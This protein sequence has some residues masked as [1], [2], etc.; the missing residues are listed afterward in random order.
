MA[1]P[2]TPQVKGVVFD[3]DGVLADTEALHLAA[4][5]EVFSKRGWRLEPQEYFSRYL[6]YDDRGL[7][8][9]FARDHGLHFTPPDTDR[10]F[11][12]KAAAYR[13]RLSAGSVL[14]AGATACITRLHKRFPLAIATGSLRD[15]VVDILTASGAIAAFDA[16]VAAD[17]GVD[18]KPSPAPYLAAASR[19]GIPPASCVA[20]EDSPGGLGSAVEAGL[21]TIGI[22]TTRLRRELERATH[23]VDALDEL[24]V[25][26][27]ESL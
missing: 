4:F 26:L 1:T 27:I 19:L 25:E 14:Y 23:V 18:P 6:G 17:D 2:V 12:E 8:D 11:T 7:I 5:Q 9:A 24:T 15:E 20:I 16:I 22:T 3:F 21:R 10:L 13:A